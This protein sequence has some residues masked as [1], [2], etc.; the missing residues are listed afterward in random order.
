MPGQL[1]LPLS[2]KGPFPGSLTLPHCTIVPWM[3]CISCGKLPELTL[4]IVTISRLLGA[5]A[6]ARIKPT[7]I[8]LQSLMLHEM[9]VLLGQPCQALMCMQA[10]VAHIAAL[11]PT[12]AGLCWRCR[13]GWRWEVWGVPHFWVA[14]HEA[15][16]T[17]PA[18]RA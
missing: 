18:P 13:S 10:V 6:V 2:G 16:H 7:D 5:I 4:P 9:Q 8:C 14:A 3:H 11:C 1:L 12:A 15:C 17:W